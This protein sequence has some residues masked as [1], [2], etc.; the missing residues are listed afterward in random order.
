MQVNNVPTFLDPS[1]RPYSLHDRISSLCLSYKNIRFLLGVAAVDAFFGKSAH[2]G[3]FVVAVIV[4]S[5][6]VSPERLERLER[7]MNV[8]VIQLKGQVH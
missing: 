8:L 1:N 2:I 6:S 7:S 5:V 3:V 4:I